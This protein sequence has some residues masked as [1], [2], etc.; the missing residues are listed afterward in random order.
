MI[1]RIKEFDWNSKSLTI[2]NCKDKIDGKLMQILVLPTVDYFLPLL[3]EGG[4]PDYLICHP[5]IWKS[6]FTE[7]APHYEK[8]IDSFEEW[9]EE[10][11]S[12]WFN[13]LQRIYASTQLYKDELISHSDTFSKEY[14]LIKFNINLKAWKS[15]LSM[16]EVKAG[17]LV[18]VELER[19]VYYH[20]FSD[21]FNEAIRIWWVALSYPDSVPDCLEPMIDRIEDLDLSKINNE[22][23]KLSLRYYNENNLE[24]VRNDSRIH[25]PP[26][27]ANHH[28]LEE[29]LT[30]NKVMSIF[31]ACAH[32]LNQDEIK[33]VV[34][35]AKE[36]I[37]S[38]SLGE[39]SDL[40]EDELITTKDLFS[41]FPSILDTHIV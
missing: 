29:A 14:N 28:I 15:I 36:Y 1:E 34:E 39:S 5:E 8:T 11:Q 2:D 30:K 19:W 13:P 4:F 37:V 17:K 18:A 33:I 41:D 32:S 7:F 10:V 35:W 3:A 27:F 38:N 24:L 20:Y 26:Y 21:R 9:A 12:K 22:I 23:K 31:Q 16:L 25:H 40:C 6:I